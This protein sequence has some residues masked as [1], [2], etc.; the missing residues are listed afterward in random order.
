[1]VLA[2]HPS[3]ST[4]VSSHFPLK[5]KTTLVTSGSRGISLKAVTGL[6]KTGISVTF[7]CSSTLEKDIALLIEVHYYQIPDEQ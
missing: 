5:W 3:P 6:L 2:V 7:T 1:M 4:L